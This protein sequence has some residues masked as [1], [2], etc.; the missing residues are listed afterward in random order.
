MARIDSTEWLYIDASST[1]LFRLGEAVC[2]GEML[3]ENVFGEAIRA[4]LNAQV[5]DIQYDIDTNQV[6]LA[7]APTSYPVGH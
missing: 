4:S 5:V 1:R 2:A 3:G 6:I 7:V